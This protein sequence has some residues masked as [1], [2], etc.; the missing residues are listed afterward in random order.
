MLLTITTTHKPASDLGFLLEKHPSK[1]HSFEL[2][3]NGYAHAH[4]PPINFGCAETR[5]CWSVNIGGGMLGLQMMK[6]RVFVEILTQVWG[7]WLSRK[8]TAAP[9]RASHS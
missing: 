8:T 1:A 4:S 5:A 7:L 6:S 3:G 2:A 9:E